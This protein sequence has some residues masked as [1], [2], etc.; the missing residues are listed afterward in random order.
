MKQS[1]KKRLWRNDVIFIAVLVAIIAV[2]AACLYLFSTEGDT[3]TVSVNGK[4]IATYPLS[5]DRVEEIHSGE[6]GLN[7]LVIKDGKAY[8][9]WANC[10]NLSTKKRC[11]AHLPIYRRGESIICQ[12]HGVVVAITSTGNADHPDVPDTVI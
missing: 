1:Q 6:E 4:E 8:V 10:P 5:V 7:R 9:E 2:G 11:T 3:V 12:P